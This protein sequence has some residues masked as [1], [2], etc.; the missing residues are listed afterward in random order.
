MITMPIKEVTSK[1]LESLNETGAAKI[2]RAW[3]AF[4]G[5]EHTYEAG[6]EQTDAEVTFVSGK[7][8]GLKVQIGSGYAVATW[9]QYD[10]SGELES[11]WSVDVEP[12]VPLSLALDK[13][14]KVR[15]K[16]SK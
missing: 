5:H 3:A 8:A 10:K 15:A 1:M 4:H 2:V 9:G 14:A 6:T 11:L 13:V 12:K 16:E 7:Y